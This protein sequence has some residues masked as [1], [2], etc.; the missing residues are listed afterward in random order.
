M[1][2]FFNP[3]GRYRRDLCL[4][5]GGALPAPERDAIEN[6]L[7]ACADCRKYY[8]EIK[9]V[10]VPLTN[11]EGNFAHLQPS[12]TAQRRWAGAV[13]AASGP[14]LV[15]RPTPAMAFRDW[16]HDV[17]W[18]CR[19]IWTGMAA[20]WVVILAAN[21]SLHEQSPAIAKSGPSTEMIMALK[22]Q[23][24]ILAELLPDHSTPPDAD[25]QKIFSPK[26]RTECVETLTA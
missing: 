26:P 1:K 12:Q 22:D 20:V 10:T 4:L 6:H 18:P 2:R 25:R 16:W 7:A 21:V 8:D 15:R 3:C 13:Q 9:A 24:R 11:W 5:A 17:I 23:Q 14:G 19:R